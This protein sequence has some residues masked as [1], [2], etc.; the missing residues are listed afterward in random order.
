MRFLWRGIAEHNPTLQSHDPNRGCRIGVGACNLL[1]FLIRVVVSFRMIR[2]NQG[3]PK[4]YE[5]GLLPY[6]TTAWGVCRKQ[7]RDGACAEVLFRTEDFAKAEVADLVRNARRELDATGQ[8]SQLDCCRCLGRR[9]YDGSV[10][11]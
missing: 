6:G 4:S 10:R 9:H 8:R 1:L 3:E 11:E 5:S 2:T 7:R